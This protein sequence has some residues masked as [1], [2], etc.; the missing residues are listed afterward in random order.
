MTTLIFFY[1]V[2]IDEKKQSY[3]QEEAQG[4]GKPT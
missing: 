4:R 1:S 3:F 2:K